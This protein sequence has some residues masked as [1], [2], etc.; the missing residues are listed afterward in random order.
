[1]KVFIIG[2]CGGSASGKST[3]ANELAGILGNDLTNLI[4]LDNYYYDFVSK[5]LNPEEINYDHPKSI[6]ISQVIDDLKLLRTG[7]P[8]EIPQY[9]LSTHTRKDLGFLIFPRRYLIVEGLFLFT[10]RSLTSLFDLKLY[11]NTPDDVRF[12]RRI[13][14]DTRERNRS[15]ASIQDQYRNYVYPMHLK[16]VLPN[17]ELADLVIQ[18]N[19]SFRDQLPEILRLIDDRQY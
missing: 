6:D 17:R 19:E 16:Y 10:I 18:G 11:V 14:R 3:L 13:E 2:I 1:M 12:Q 4:S 8:V 7:K 15:L 5:G 9:D